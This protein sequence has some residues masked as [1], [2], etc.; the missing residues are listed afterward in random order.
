VA[1]KPVEPAMISF[2]IYTQ[3]SRSVAANRAV[4]TGAVGGQVVA[5]LVAQSVA[6][7]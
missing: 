4:M 7:W 2:M 1:T 3:F 6:G 5:E